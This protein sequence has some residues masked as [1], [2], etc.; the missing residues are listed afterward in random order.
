M[1]S[2]IH[3]PFLGIKGLEKGVCS[4]CGVDSEYETFCGRKR[5]KFALIEMLKQSDR[6]A[7]DTHRVS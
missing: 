4:W 6:A 1:E 3:T 7:Y 2:A 5:K